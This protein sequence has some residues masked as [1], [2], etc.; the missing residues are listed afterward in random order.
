MFLIRI[1]ISPIIDD[2]DGT[3]LTARKSSTNP[4]RPSL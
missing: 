1:S 3:L 4:L 2:P